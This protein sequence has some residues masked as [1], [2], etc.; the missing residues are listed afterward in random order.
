[1]LARALAHDLAEQRITVCIGNPGRYGESDS[2]EFGVPIDESAA[3]LLSVM[4]RCAPEQS[5]AFVD[6]TGSE[7]AW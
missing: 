7:R 5:G 1:M 6:W 4:D 2:H 3:G